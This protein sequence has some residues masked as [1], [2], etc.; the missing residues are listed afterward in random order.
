[1][2]AFVAYYTLRHGQNRV[3]NAAANC[4]ELHFREK[5]STQI[6]SKKV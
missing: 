4:E 2:M 6:F 1:M 3:V 5:I